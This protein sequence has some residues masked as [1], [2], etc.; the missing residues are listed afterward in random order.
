VDGRPK[1][2]EIRDTKTLHL[3]RNIISLQIL[4]RC[5]P[6]FILRDQLVAQQGHLL[7]RVEEVV[8]KSRA[9][10]QFEEQIL[11]LLFLFHHTYSL[12]HAST[13]SKSTNQRAAF[14]QPATN[15][16]VARQ[17]DNAK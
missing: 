1:G 12:S 13:P 8:S 10:G 14:L 2:G 11:A 7:L 6:L 3:P 4:G 5:F 9:R 15:V 17:V 16:F